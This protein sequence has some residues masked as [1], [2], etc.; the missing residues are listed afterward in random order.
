MPAQSGFKQTQS[1]NRKPFKP[2]QRD[3]VQFYTD[4]IISAGPHKKKKFYKIANL[5]DKKDW[6]SDVARPNGTNHQLLLT[7]TI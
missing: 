7:N 2:H 4:R 5:S 3:N 1:S 6:E